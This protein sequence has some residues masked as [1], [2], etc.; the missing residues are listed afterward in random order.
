MRNSVLNG[1]LFDIIGT[2]SYVLVE[3]RTVLCGV[4][5]RIRGNN[6]RTL[7][8]AKC[9]ITSSN[10][11]IEDNMFEIMIWWQ[12]TFSEMHLAATE[13]FSRIVFDDD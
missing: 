2:K 3:A 8:G 4:T 5:F 13:N 1:L 9:R 10:I 12:T 7:I 6:N 11:W